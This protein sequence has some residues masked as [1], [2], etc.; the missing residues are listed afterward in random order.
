MLGVQTLRS[1]RSLMRLHP[2]ITATA[3]NKER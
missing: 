1:H 3:S 2:R